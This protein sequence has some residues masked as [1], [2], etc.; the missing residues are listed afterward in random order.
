MGGSA[1]LQSVSKPQVYVAPAGAVAAGSPFYVA[2]YLACIKLKDISDYFKKCPM[3]KNTRE[4]IYLNYNSSSTTLV[5]TGSA[6]VIS[7]STIASLSNNMNFGNTC[8]V[9]WNL[10][11]GTSTTAL[12][13]GLNLPASACTLTI[14]A[15]INSTSATGSGITPSQT[16][17]NNLQITV[18][19]IP[20]W[21]NPVSFGYDLFL[22]EMSSS[23]VDGG[24]DDTTSAG[25]LSQRQW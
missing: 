6:G 12:A 9:M 24:L 1:N 4:F 14:T 11:S 5:T 25:L 21:N 16:F 2:H 23:G 15:D 18:G 13:G 7:T 19:N 17:S 8:P 20:I 22:Q 10:S 3:Q